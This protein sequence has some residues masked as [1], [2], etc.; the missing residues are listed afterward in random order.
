MSK[1]SQLFEGI[2]L[3]AYTPKQIIDSKK[4]YDYIIESA[5][6]AKEEGK[7]LEEIMDEG[8]LTGLIG[9]AAGL[10]VGPAIMKSILKVLG[11]SEHSVLGDL[12]TSRIVLSAVCAE[13]GLRY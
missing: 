5:E 2:D 3:S 1:Y 7:P 12:L 6:V 4:L 11:I 8:I 9:A 10:T 13:L